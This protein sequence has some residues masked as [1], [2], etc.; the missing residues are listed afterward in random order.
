MC[1]SHNCMF[2]A[3]VVGAGWRW[4]CSHAPVS[5]PQGS[6]TTSMIVCEWMEP[7]TWSTWKAPYKSNPLLL[8]CW[9]CQSIL[10]DA[11]KERTDPVDDDA[12]SDDSCSSY[13][14]N[15]NLLVHPTFAMPEGPQVRSRIFIKNTIN[16]SPATCELLFCITCLLKC[17]CT[18]I[19]LK[20]LSLTILLLLLSCHCL[21]IQLNF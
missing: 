16:L 1:M 20:G 5:L 19:Y 15:R 8:K 3:V 9:L 18:L 7:G 17:S 11:Q 13:S 14:T 4:M 10:S 21:M 6:C 12:K 2:A